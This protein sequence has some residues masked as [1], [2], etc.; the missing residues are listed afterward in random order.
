[1]RGLMQELRVAGVRP[2]M[3]TGDQSATAQA[4]GQQIGL[5][6]EGSLDQIDS[7]QLDQLAPDVLRELAP[8]VDVF[9]RV[10]PSHKLQIVRALQAA[11]YVVAMT[12][13]GINDGP[14]LKAAD[15]GIA[16]GQGGT[17]VARDVADIVLEDDNLET[18]VEAI[19]EGRTVYDD[20]RKAVGF[21]LATNSSEIA[22][23]I[24]LAAAG[25][26]MLTP[27]QLLW[28]NLISDIF[29]EL[30]LAQEPAEDDVLRRPPRDQSRAMFAGPELAHGALQGFLIAGSALTAGALG[31]PGQRAVTRTFLSLVGAQLLHAISARSARRSLFDAQKHPRN[32]GLDLAI[33]GALLATLVGQISP[34]L[35]GVLGSAPI[36][37]ADWAVVAGG[38][39]APFLVTELSKLTADARR[40]LPAPDDDDTAAAYDDA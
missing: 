26:P 9:S 33:S 38:T 27:A 7:T 31:V 28:I 11:G 25:R 32:R 8:R 22:V 36:G 37:A 16:M 34:A 19:R 5:A 21:L 29:P 18:L 17:A 2:M 24:A 15:V 14:A 3:V 39:F 12:G 20:V 4:V 23:S 30:A 35:R 6:D 40:Q 13:D 10:S 1:M